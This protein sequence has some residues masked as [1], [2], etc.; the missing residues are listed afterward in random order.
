MGFSSG[1]SDKEPTGQ[2][3]KHKRCGFHS[4]LERF[5]G[6]GPGKPLQYSCLEKPMDKGAWW[7][8]VHKITKSLRH[9]WSD[10]ACTHTNIALIISILILVLMLILKWELDYKESWAPKNWCFW[11]VVLEKRLFWESLGL[12]GDPTSP[13]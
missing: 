5:P 13:S 8:M 6:G 10:L 3:R 12:Q 9:Y 1:A 4:G 11:T 7:A 2:C